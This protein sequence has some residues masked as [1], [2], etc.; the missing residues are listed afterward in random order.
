[1]KIYIPNVIPVLCKSLQ[2]LQ[3]FGN[4]QNLCM[5]RGT[6]K[7]ITICDTP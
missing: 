7:G 3:G 6:K 1:M 4:Q 5:G 2:G